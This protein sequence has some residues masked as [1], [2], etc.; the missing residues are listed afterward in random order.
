[1]EQ[2]I[3]VDVFS[4]DVF[5]EHISK[6][7]KKYS[8]N[9]HF[10]K[11]KKIVD[12][13]FMNPEADYYRA[14]TDKFYET[15]HWAV[16][17]ISKSSSYT[18]DNENSSKEKDAFK[19]ILDTWEA[20]HSFEQTSYFPIVMSIIT[21]DNVV[22]HPGNTRIAMSQ[23]DKFKNSVADLIIVDYTGNYN[24]N[25][26]FDNFPYG[27]KITEWVNNPAKR[28]V[29]FFAPKIM[30]DTFTFVPLNYDIQVYYNGRTIFFNNVPILSLDHK[31]KKVI[32]ESTHNGLETMLCYTNT[33]EQKKHARQ[34][35]LNIV[36]ANKKAIT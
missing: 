22:I 25:I 26:S 20:Y 7:S 34:E 4:R 12:I 24:T 21:S 30:H 15:I 33:P 36:H 19:N 10:I 23:Y 3:D 17:T 32:Y 13:A 28:N 14:F 11:N 8:C 2:R 1:M 29:E 9:F 16:E 18:Y 31:N 27:V 5:D 35:A 6:L